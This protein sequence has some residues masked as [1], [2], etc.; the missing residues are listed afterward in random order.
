LVIVLQTAFAGGYEM[1]K[2][3]NDKNTNAKKLLDNIFIDF[4][5]D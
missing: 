4:M 3:T 2:K 1:S 5:D